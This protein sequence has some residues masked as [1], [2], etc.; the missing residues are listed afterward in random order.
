[1]Y[2]KEYITFQNYAENLQDICFD[3]CNS[4][5][6]PDTRWESWDESAKP[7]CY[8]TSGSRCALLQVAEN[9]NGSKVQKEA[10]S[11]VNYK[12]QNLFLLA[13]VTWYDIW[14]CE[15]DTWVHGN[16]ADITPTK[17]KALTDFLQ[18]YSEKGFTSAK[19]IPT[20]IEYALDAKPEFKEQFVKRWH[21]K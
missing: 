15:Q 3:L 4:K 13:A 2:L 14:N 12:L 18:K 6:L 21:R 11:I 7:I 20:E 16:V 19:S 9:P 5:P 1:M 10:E 8:Q 17:I